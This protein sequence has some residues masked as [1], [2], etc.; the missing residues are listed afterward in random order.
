MTR[1]QKENFPIL[2]L[3]LLRSNMS[4]E[5]HLS[6]LLLSSWLG[7]NSSLSLSASFH[8]PFYH[9]LHI[10]V[11]NIVIAWYLCCLCD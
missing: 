3:Q 1:K 11:F 9:H 2:Q 5:F 4:T 6:V 8:H 7:I 10:C